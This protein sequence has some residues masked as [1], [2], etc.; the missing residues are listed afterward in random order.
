MLFRR[1][2]SK[3]ELENPYFSIRIINE[4]IQLTTFLSHFLHHF[5]IVTEYYPQLIITA[6]YNN[7]IRVTE[8]A[9]INLMTWW[10][11]NIVD[12][13]IQEM[14]ADFTSFLIKTFSKGYK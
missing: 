2:H 5:I 12:I 11:I 3:G 10:S 1:A 14:L 6:E 9:N 7:V 13:F 8:E 4:R